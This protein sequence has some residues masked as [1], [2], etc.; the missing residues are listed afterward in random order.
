MF[1]CDALAGGC[2]FGVWELVRL[3]LAYRDGKRGMGRMRGG[4]GALMCICSGTGWYGMR[5]S[6]MM[7]VFWWYSYCI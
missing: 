3:I 1:A 4:M 5:T 7:A 6:V 2:W